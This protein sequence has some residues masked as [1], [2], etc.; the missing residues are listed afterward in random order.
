MSEPRLSIEELAQEFMHTYPRHGGRIS[1]AAPIFDRQP[2][3]LAKA[4]NRAKQRGLD[5]KFIDDS[6]KARVA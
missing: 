6:Y 2:N 5:A 1:V 4:L 3:S